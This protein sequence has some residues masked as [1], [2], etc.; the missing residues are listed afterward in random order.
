MISVQLIKKNI[1]YCLE[2]MPVCNELDNPGL[3]PTDES[4]M[5]GF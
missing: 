4:L 2:F 3:I 5:A 1:L